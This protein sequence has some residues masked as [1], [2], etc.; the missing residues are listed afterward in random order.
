MFKITFKIIK[1]DISNSLTI[2]NCITT[3]NLN[4]WNVSFN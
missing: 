2:T 1:I 4:H 3:T